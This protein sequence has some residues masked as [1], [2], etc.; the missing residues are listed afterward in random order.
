MEIVDL[1]VTGDFV[2]LSRVEDGKCGA[3]V[4][5]H[6]GC[7]TEVVHAQGEYFGVLLPDAGIVALQLDELPETYPSEEAAIEDEHDVLVAAE[8]G[9]GDVDATVGD[10]EAEVWSSFYAFE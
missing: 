9:E 5:D 4:C 8:V 1:V 2:V 6:S 3:G 10:R 7:T